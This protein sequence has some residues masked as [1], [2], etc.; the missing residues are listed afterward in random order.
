ML[1]EFGALKT[2]RRPPDRAAAVPI[3]AMQT[4]T[5]MRKSLVAEVYLGFLG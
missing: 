5:R 4:N 3:E 2:I 1:I